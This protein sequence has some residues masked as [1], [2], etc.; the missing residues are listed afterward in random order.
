MQNVPGTFKRNFKFILL[1]L[2]LPLLVSCVAPGT[3]HGHLGLTVNVTGDRDPPEQIKAILP[4]S[5]GLSG[6]DKAFGSTEDYGQERTIRKTAFIDTQARIKFPRVN[7]HTTVFIFPPLGADPAHPPPPYFRIRFSNAK[8]EVYLVRLRDKETFYRVREE[9]TDRKISKRDA[10]WTVKN[11]SY[12]SAPLETE[13]EPDERW[14][15]SLEL[16]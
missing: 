1:C 2:T 9:G 5:Y 16:E 14:Y 13:T 11:V 8:D 4:A 15:L 10:T 12:D 3:G 7:Y 6:L